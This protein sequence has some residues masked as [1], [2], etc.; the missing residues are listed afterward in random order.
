MRTKNADTTVTG[1]C[2]QALKHH[3]TPVYQALTGAHNTS[4][5][6]AAA[7]VAVHTGE[8]AMLRLL[9]PNCWCAHARHQL[10]VS[11]RT[12]PSVRHA[13][14]LLLLLIDRLQFGRLLLAASSTT[15][16]A[17]LAT[18]RR[19]CS[20][21][22]SSRPSSSCCCCRQLLVCEASGHC[23]GWVIRPGVPGVPALHLLLDLA[24][25]L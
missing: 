11:T 13:S 16:T 14:P 19:C 23:I 24:I 21:C 4:I 20:C 12:W 22:I 9:Q 3:S 8:I 15:A 7:H 17:A 18:R 1:G 2:F 25:C 10:E 5:N 6:K